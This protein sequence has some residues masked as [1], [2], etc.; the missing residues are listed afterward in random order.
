M[1]LLGSTIL[2]DK[3]KMAA[4]KPLI[5]SEHIHGIV[6]ADRGF[7]G[8]EWV[9]LSVGCQGGL[10]FF[11]VLGKKGRQ[12]RNFRSF[13]TEGIGR[14]VLLI[15]GSPRKEVIERPVEAFQRKAQ[16]RTGIVAE[17]ARIQKKRQV[18][19]QFGKV[20]IQRGGIL[21]GIENPQSTQAHGFRSAFHRFGFPLFGGGIGKFLGAGIAQCGKSLPFGGIPG[22]A[23]GGQRA[24]FRQF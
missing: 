3:E 2:P 1:E 15:Q 22:A 18:V 8:V 21:G 7:A 9:S 17:P 5:Q 12:R 20:A 19:L 11:E 13:K 6:T 14:A 24:V 23:G 4:V 16:H 10:L